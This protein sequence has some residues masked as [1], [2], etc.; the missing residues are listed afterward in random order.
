MPA[1]TRSKPIRPSS[2]VVLLDSDTLAI[3][4]NNKQNTKKPARKE[5]CPINSGEIIEISS[6]EDEGPVAPRSA[7]TTSKL[8]ERIRQLE[9]ENARIK[10]ENDEIKRQ[11]TV[12]ADLEDQITCEVCNSKMWSPFILPDCGHTFCQKDLEDWFSTALKQH[13]NVYPH[14]NVNVPLNIY[15]VFQQ[16]LPLPPY[17]CPK[18]REKVRSKP[19]QNFAV[20][21]F[22][23]A[24]A[25]QAGE[26]SPKKTVGSATNVWNH[27]F[28]Q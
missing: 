27:F 10:K 4:R 19:V 25:E 22:V 11:K 12:A 24:V 18:C 23:R 20:K 7:V 21:G 3:K 6:D 1:N 26:T 15:G 16:Q 5:N 8:Q 14:Y 13:R 2:D 9:T 17:T 28:P